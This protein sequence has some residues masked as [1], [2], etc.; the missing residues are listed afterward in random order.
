VFL[1]RCAVDFIK[2]RL[3]CGPGPIEEKSKDSTVDQTEKMINTTK[4]CLHL[5]AVN[6]I[7]K[8]SLIANP[9]MDDL[10]PKITMGNMYKISLGHPASP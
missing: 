6:L 2:Q 7:L 1:E 3:A 8:G 10:I 9:N 4:P 5:V